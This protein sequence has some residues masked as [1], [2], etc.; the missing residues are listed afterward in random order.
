MTMQPQTKRIVG[1]ASAGL[2]AAILI[3]TPFVAQLEGK[4]NDPY[5]DTVGVMTVCY[6]ETNVKMRRYS[7]AECLAMFKRSLEG[8]GQRVVKCT[9]GI[10]D[11]PRVL[12]SATSFAYNVGSA[13]YCRSTTAKLF[14]QGNLAAGCRAMMNWV[15]PPEIRGRRQKETNLCLAGANNVRS[16]N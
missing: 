12:A 14:N 6:G 1:G 11:N 2:A 9:P 7:D 8:Y 15:T 5:Y 13:G 3:A 10:V 4:R 16:G